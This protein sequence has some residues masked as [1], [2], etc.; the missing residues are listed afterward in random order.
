MSIL[1]SLLLWMILLALSWPLAIAVLILW[2]IVWLISL[3]LRLIG[4]TLSAVFT[5]FKSILLLPA[6]LLGWRPAPRAN[7]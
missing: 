5:L 1:V 3:P 2:P 4:I 7:A 6:Y